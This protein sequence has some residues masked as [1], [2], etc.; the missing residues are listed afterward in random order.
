MSKHMRIT[1]KHL[2]A[3]VSIVNRLLGF[4]PDT[5]EHNTVGSIQLYHAIGYS[6]HRVHNSAH[7]V[8]DISGSAG[9]ARE[10]S[11]FLQGMIAALR[12]AW[13]ASPERQATHDCL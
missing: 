6:V 11:A 12:L 4:D 5:L 3:K 10:I 13:E 8:E 9:T 1:R 2:E 7:G